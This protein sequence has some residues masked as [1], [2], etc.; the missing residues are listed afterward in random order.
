MDATTSRDPQALHAFVVQWIE[1][2]FAVPTIQVRF[3]ARALERP[4]AERVAL[5]PLQRARAVKKICKIF[6]FCVAEP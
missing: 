5:A 1:Y 6:S 4:E 2:G 3:L